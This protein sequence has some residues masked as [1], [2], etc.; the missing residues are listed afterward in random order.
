[1]KIH[2]L[3]PAAFLCITYQGCGAAP[4]APIVPARSV[5]PAPKPVTLPP[6]APIRLQ[7][8]WAK[9]ADTSGV[10]DQDNGNDSV[11]SCEF[12]PD[13]K[14][15][16]AG[17]KGVPTPDGK[18]HGARVVVYDAATG[19]EI[20]SHPREEEVEAVSFSPC[21]TFLAA[22]GEDLLNI[23]Y[24][25]ADGKEIARLPATASFDS[26]RF[27]PCGRWLIGGTE[28]SDLRIYRTAD[29]REIAAIPFGVPGEYGIN[30]IDFTADG[31]FLAAAGGW[32]MQS[33]IW[34]LVDSTAAD[35]GPGLRLVLRH[36]LKNKDGSIKSN[37]FSPDGGLLA[38]SGG[39]AIGTTVWNLHTG[40]IVVE[41]PPTSPAIEAVEWTPC[42]RFLLTGGTEG[43]DRPPDQLNPNY[44]NNSGFGHIR[45]YAA[46]K[47]WPE[48]ARIPVFRQEY[49]H[50]TRDGSRLVSGHEDGSVRVW[51]VDITPTPTTP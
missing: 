19:R 7:L 4:Q 1:M 47:N 45:I 31:K 37:R 2:L 46:D 24:Q 10:M 30:S 42:G 41:L 21:G 18:H 50:F 29:W 44:P 6:D 3:L 39:F 23:I 49:Y 8:L 38:M 51:K 11:E 28:D 12:S 13:G 33:R 32:S 17:T 48:V 40:R 36:A 43:F 9:Q 20:W 26:L 27:S 35:G 25:A 14:R 22:A 5:K 15:V 34:E 16:A